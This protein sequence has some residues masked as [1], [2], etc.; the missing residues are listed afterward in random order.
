MKIR[1][2]SPGFL[3]RAAVGLAFVLVI[4][5]PMVFPN[6]VRPDPTAL[7]RQ[8]AVAAAVE[9]V[10]YQIGR[11]LGT[12]VP[13]PRSAVELLR[14]NA[15]LS[16]RFR[17]AEGGHSVSLLV[18]HCMDIRDMRGHYP[19]NCYP[20]AGWSVADD[21][22]SGKATLDF[23]G[24]RLPVEVYAFRRIEDGIRE[25]RIRIYNFFVLQDGRVT[26]DIGE[27]RARSERLALSAQGVAQIPILTLI[28][29]PPVEAVAAAN[30]FLEGLT[31]LL[32]A[33]GVVEG[34]EH[35]A[36]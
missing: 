16:R 12:D 15:F 1:R 30:E 6:H 29:M 27:L 10:P 11:W 36:P 31:G 9:V 21:P 24:R 13:I 18:V 8:V 2:A 19:P 7:A 20:S 32:T 33:L 23:D 4:V 5:L 26:T 25:S 17:R 34:G 22:A 35:D 28:E 14:P 3:N